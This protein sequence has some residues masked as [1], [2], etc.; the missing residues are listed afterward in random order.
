[1]SF[2]GLNYQSRLHQREAQA[3]VTRA[4]QLIEISKERDHF[5]VE[6]ARLREALEAIEAALP[7]G[8]P[9]TNTMTLS[10]WRTAFRGL[11][12]LARLARKGVVR[13][14]EI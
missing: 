6:N 8:D 2:F 5:K 1:M 9:D 10:D 13:R 7:V 3:N 11:Q 12:T 4:E 14:G